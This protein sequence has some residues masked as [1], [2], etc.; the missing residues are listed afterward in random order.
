MISVSEIRRILRD[1]SLTDESIG[2]L[3]D[4]LYTLARVQFETPIDDTFFLDTENE[5]PYLKLH[6]YSKAK[7]LPVD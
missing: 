4:T 1:D 6:S 7:L 2:R 3:R 5:T